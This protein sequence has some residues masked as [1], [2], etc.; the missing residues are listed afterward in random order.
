MIN[1]LILLKLK[2]LISFRNSSYLSTA[3][4]DIFTVA[5][6]IKNFAANL[7]DVS[8]KTVTRYQKE[9]KKLSPLQSEYILKT[10][11][12]FNKGNQLFGNKESFNCWL[13]KPAFGLG[14]SIPRIFITKVGSINYVIEELSR[15][16]H[17]D[18]A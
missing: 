13:D 5:S 2:N 15:I 6:Y 10:I 7:L 4:N 3:V 14:N 16:A 12:L 9:K 17:G 8:Y 1:T 11:V 18:L